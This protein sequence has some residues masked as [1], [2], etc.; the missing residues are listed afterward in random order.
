MVG[1]NGSSS[2]SRELPEWL[3]ATTESSSNVGV[4][5]SHDKKAAMTKSH[6]G[7]TGSHD[8]KGYCFLA[9]KNASAINKSAG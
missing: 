2:R 4:A 9:R 8:R 1:A 5:I 7:R 3:S 6:D